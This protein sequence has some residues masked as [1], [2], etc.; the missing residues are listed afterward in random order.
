[1]PTNPHARFFALLRKLPQSSEEDLIWKH[2]RTVTTSLSEFYRKMP[3]EYAQMIAAMQ[4]MVDQIHGKQQPD[5]AE[6]A[7]KRRFRSLILG[8]LNE[9]GIVVKNWDYSEVNAIIQGWTKSQ[10]TLKTMT[11]DELKKLS[12]QIHSIMD[13]YSKKQSTINKQAKLN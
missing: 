7:Q 6:E 9:W 2:S 3:C 13:W 10:K 12:R 4:S 8:K 1:M 11:L 5:E